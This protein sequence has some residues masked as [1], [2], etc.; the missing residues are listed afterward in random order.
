MKTVFS[1]AH[2]LQSVQTEFYRGKWV[3]AFEIPRRAELVLAA[4]R[5]ADLGPVIA[6]T[7]FGL[8][9]VQAVHD[10]AFLRFWKRCGTT[11]WPRSE[12]SRPIP[13]SG[14]RGGRG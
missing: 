11:G 10:A 7:G 12:R 2:A 13:T 4:V 8:A 3:E 6:P 5:Q 9:P 14:R 1:E